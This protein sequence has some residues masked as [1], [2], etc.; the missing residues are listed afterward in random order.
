MAELDGRDENP[1]ETVRREMCVGIEGL[2]DH[3]RLVAEAASGQNEALGRKL[4][5]LDSKVDRLHEDN[6][7][8]HKTLLSM[9]GDHETRIDS[10]ERK[11]K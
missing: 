9:L 10:L 4:E 5:A 6:L 11:A 8:Q 1:L 3:I 2:H 7:A